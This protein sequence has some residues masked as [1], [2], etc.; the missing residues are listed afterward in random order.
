[1][2]C[3]GGDDLLV[4]ICNDILGKLPANF[5]MEHAKKKYPT[6]P[7]ESM[8]TV[9]TQELLRFNKLTD[10]IK[11]LLR[12]VQSALSGDPEAR[13]HRRGATSYR[14]TSPAAP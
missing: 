7:H 3:S 10:L 13:S 5:N 1:M 11:R 14:R 9:L 4:E 2:W 6:L 12:E 8:N